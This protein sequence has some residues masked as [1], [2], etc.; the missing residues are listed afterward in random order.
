V[1]AATPI[2]GVTM[3][4]VDFFAGL[5][6]NAVGALNTT[7]AADIVLI[8]VP[9][10]TETP[11]A[12]TLDPYV[13]IPGLGRWYL[14]ADTGPLTDDDYL[15]LG[16]GALLAL[17]YGLPGGTPLPDNMNLFT[18]DPG[19][20]LRAAEVD[21]INAQ[22]DG[23]NAAIDQTA[24]AFGYPVFDV[25]AFFAAITSG[26]YVPTY[27]GTT[28]STQ[29]LLG[30]IFSY[31]GIHP[32]RIGYALMADEL[33]QFINAEYGS[34]IP[35]VD[36]AEV[37]F[38]GD[39]Q[40]PSMSSGKAQENVRRRES[41]GPTQIAPSLRAETSDAS[42]QNDPERSLDVNTRPGRMPG[43][44]LLVDVLVL[45]AIDDVEAAFALETFEAALEDETL[46]ALAPIVKHATGAAHFEPGVGQEDRRR[47]PAEPREVL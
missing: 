43:P 31:D 41:A 14:M 5:Y 6:G 28:L 27:G 46:A 2:D 8:N 21:L 37:L 11:F 1:L 17:G 23:Y 30:G 35:R 16:G 15:T 18:G 34:E 7:T 32:Q 38:E 10:P 26:E 29:F 3:T 9:Y 39:W 47:D 40:S 36:M 20:V 4:P 13:D 24:S 12:T 33:I 25:N 22:V 42:R 45:V 44:L 19:V